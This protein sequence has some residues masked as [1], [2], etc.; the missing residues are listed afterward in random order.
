MQDNNKKERSEAQKRADKK[1]NAKIR[2]VKYTPLNLSVF[3]DDKL[4]IDEFCVKMD[5]SKAR[6][7]V[8]ACK[9][10]IQRGELPPESNADD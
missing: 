6:F 1:Y 5:I 9:Y 7:I 10:F 8:G 2:G 3:T 4:Q